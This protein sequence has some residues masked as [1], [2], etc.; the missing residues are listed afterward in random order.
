MKLKYKMLLLVNLVVV[1][2]IAAIVVMPTAIKNA[3][4]TPKVLWIA[5]VWTVLCIGVLT[6]T[7]QI[8]VRM[9]RRDPPTSQDS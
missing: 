7:G 1:L 8:V 3:D 6:L 5:V 4:N 9:S 2:I